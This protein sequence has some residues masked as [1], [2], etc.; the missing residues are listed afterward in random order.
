M[1]GAKETPYLSMD[2]CDQCSHPLADGPIVPV[3]VMGEDEHWDTRTASL[4]ERCL[5]EAIA[6]LE[7][8]S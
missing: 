1:S 2:R 3:V 8:K 6:M 7:A 4:C 5:R